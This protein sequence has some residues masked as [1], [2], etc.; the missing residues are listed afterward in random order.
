[1]KYCKL[2]KTDISISRVTHGCMELGGGR[3]KTL[4]KES[5]SALLKTAL[6]NGITTF[7]TAEGYGAGA[8]ELIVGEALKD[9]RKDCVIATKVLPDNLRAADVRKAAEG[10]LKRLQTDYIDLLYVHWPNAGI[11]IT[12]TLGEFIKLKEEGKIRA[13]GVSNFSLEQL[14]EA[15]EITHIDALQPEY[16]LLQRKIEDG[17]LSYC[18]DNQIS[19]LSYNSIAKGIL[20]GVFHFNGVKLDAEDFRNEKPLF[21]PEN[22]ETEKPLMN[23]LKA[24]AQVHNGTIS[25]IA[26]AWVLA[27]RGMSSAII[28]TQNPRHFVENIHSVD[29][30]LTQEEIDV[31]NKTSSE[32]IGK[33]IGV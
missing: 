25:Q 11:P 28:G 12:E 16:N 18:A 31:L 1:M 5:N 14:K 27:Q 33:L 21:F 3:W 19:V 30:E 29:I 9:R 24:V 7:D 23:S 13:I 32:V 10:S 22:L 2:G 4:D 20:S 17:L 8:S 26:A 15:M 6:E